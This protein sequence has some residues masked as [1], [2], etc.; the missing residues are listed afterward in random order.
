MA[1]AG[2]VLTKTIADKQ[3]E[4]ALLRGGNGESCLKRINRFLEEARSPQPMDVH[5]FLGRLKALDFSVPYCENGGENAVRVM[6]MHASKGLEFPVVILSN[7][8]RAFRVGDSDEALYVDGYGLAPKAY[9]TKKMLYAS[10]VLRLLNQRR[11]VLEDIRDEL[12]LYYV[13]LTRAQYALHMLF[14]ERS[15]G[16]DACYGKSYEDITDFD[17]WEKYERTGAGMDLPRLERQ[18]LAL[19]TEIDRSLVDG[20]LRAQEWVYSHVGCENMP[21]KT[22][23]TAL[24]K[25]LAAETPEQRM[26]AF[27]ENPFEDGQVGDGLFDSVDDGGGA[28]D[29]DFSEVG[30]S[31]AAEPLTGSA[32]H[33]FLERFDFSLLNG[34]QGNRSALKS[35]VETL[36][37]RCAKAIF[38]K[39]ILPLLTWK[40]WRKFWIIPCFTASA[41]H[42]F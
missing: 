12:N 23:S 27:V 35:L 1:T 9:D 26:E 32:Y 24:L 7:L 41:A 17:V 14:T 36:W 11:E 16:S 29:V 19:E 39:N 15:D 18:A 6:T 25:L 13:A 42:G 30:K 3:M 40:S 33:A 2:E 8:G 37:F 28:A 31:F 38:P 22:S 10:T 5:E 21:A 34:L 20:I 4:A